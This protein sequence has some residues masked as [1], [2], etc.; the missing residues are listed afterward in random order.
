M[1]TIAL[2][3]AVLLMSCNWS[4]GFSWPGSDDEPDRA[5]VSIA[6]ATVTSPDSGTAPD[7]ELDTGDTTTTEWG[8]PD[9]GGGGATT[10][11]SS[12][13]QEISIELPSPKLEVA[14]GEHFEVT[15][16]MLDGAGNELD[17]A[18]LGIPVWYECGDTGTTHVLF[19][20]L[21]NFPYVHKGVLHFFQ[22]P[23]TTDVYVDTPC[24]DAR[25]FGSHAPDGE[26]IVGASESFVVTE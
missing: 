2:A 5:P 11:P 9:T 16:R 26:H 19:V 7:T 12:G 15:F 18:N 22:H 24:A 21:E 1:K 23:M 14:A 10:D 20:V 13:L 6:G 25:L 17:Y 4:G 8:D 3:P